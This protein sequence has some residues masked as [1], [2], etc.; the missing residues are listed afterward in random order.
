MKANMNDHVA[1]ERY[2]M[3]QQSAEN[4]E[5]LLKAMVKDVG[6]LM[7]N[8]TDEVYIQMRR[9]YC[10]TLG[11]DDVPQDGQILPR[12]Q[13]SMR[14]EIMKVIDGVESTFRKVA[15]LD[16]S[17]ENGEEENDDK[18]DSGDDIGVKMGEIKTEGF[19][20]EAYR[21]KEKSTPP[22]G[23]TSDDEEPLSFSILRKKTAASG[24]DAIAEGSHHESDT[25]S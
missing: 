11:G 2:T 25:D 10:S 3:F 12:D 20:A 17:E 7:G 23:L 6:D 1:Q 14:K 19:N 16:M 18:G 15:G 4:V 21:T 8:K 9:D 13:R 22:G 5:N 24:E